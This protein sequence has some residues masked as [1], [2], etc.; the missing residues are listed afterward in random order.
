[1]DFIL[2]LVVYFVAKKQKIVLR[3]YPP[4]NDGRPGLPQIKNHPWINRN[5]L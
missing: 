5:D 2:L 4:Y 1:M 3:E